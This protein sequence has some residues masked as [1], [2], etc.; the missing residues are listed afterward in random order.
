MWVNTNWES[1]PLFLQLA[2]RKQNPVEVC[3]DARARWRRNPPASCVGN[4]WGGALDG[5]R[6]NDG[7]ASSHPTVFVLRL[8]GQWASAGG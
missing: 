3:N 6:F 5:S 1:A 4:L 8:A 2:V 7:D